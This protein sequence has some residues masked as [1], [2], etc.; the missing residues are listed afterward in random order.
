MS[1]YPQTQLVRQAQI[2]NAQGYLNYARFAETA[3]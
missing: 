3:R 2:A 1:A